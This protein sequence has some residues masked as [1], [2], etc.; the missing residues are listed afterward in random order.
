MVATWKFFRT[1][2][3]L[4]LLR[5]TYWLE[6]LF[7]CVSLKKMLVPTTIYRRATEQKRP[8]DVLLSVSK[9]IPMKG[10]TDSLLGLSK[11]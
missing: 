7:S 3:A 5:G 6:L 10:D 8:G 9:S 4:L 2:H 11:Q 1:A